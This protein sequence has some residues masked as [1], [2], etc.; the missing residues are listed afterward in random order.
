ML[1]K[2][3]LPASVYSVSKTLSAKTRTFIVV[4]GVSWTGHEDPRI[5]NLAKA[6]AAACPTNLVV[7]PYYPP[8]ALCRLGDG[9][10]QMIVDT[11]NAT[12]ADPTLCPSGKL[13]MASPCISAG[14]SIVATAHTDRVESMLGIGPHSSVKNALDHG[15][16]RLG[17]DDSRY[18]VN[19]VLGSFLAPPDAP[20][21]AML[22]A[23]VKDDHCLNLNI[24]SNELTPLLEKYPEEAAIYHR[25]HNDDKFL[26]EKLTEVYYKNEGELVAM[27]PMEKLNEINLQNLVLVHAEKDDIV[28]PKES[29]IIRDGFKKR[30]DVKVWMQITDLLNHGDQKSVGLGDALKILRMIDTFSGFFR[31]GKKVLSEKSH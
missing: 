7:V 22:A 5:V 23:Y 25:L 30:P 18:G 24:E 14:F 28:P 21:T 11:I 26:T 8:L 16:E 19:A 4:H 6:I 15:L 27:S 10:V 9:V 29:V 31:P 1:T 12:V 3:K 13:S 17:K 20:L 2:A